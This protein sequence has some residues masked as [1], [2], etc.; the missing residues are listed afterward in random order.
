MLCFMFPGQPLAHDAALPGDAD[1]AEISTL[2]LDR[3]GLDPASFSWSNE[4]HTEQVALQVY[5]VAMS[6]HRHRRLLAEGGEPAVIAEHSMGI[7]AALAA[8]G[9]I[10]EGDA[11]EMAFRAGDAME[12]R[13]RGREYALGCVVGM[14]AEQVRG[15]AVEGGVFL[16]NH[17]TSHHVLLAGG[18]H[19]MEA[20][21]GEAQRQGAFSVNLFPCDAPL[22][23][24]LLAEAEEELT[25][26]FRDYRYGDPAIPLMNHIDQRFLTSHAI[27]D[28]LMRELTEAV[29]WE[30]TYCG[31][32][33]FGVTR[34][35]EVGVGDALKK[36]NR[37]IESRL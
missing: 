33:A 12:R 36:F 9:S 37:W 32:K 18:R 13:F 19:E 20:T 26:L 4:A 23:T 22:H 24:P 17:N 15:V 7:Y 14:A 16:A 10:S 1:F 6:L 11:L 31:L 27:P 21:L 35:V 2:A 28:F 25:A 30:R 5:G 34:F 3:T 8:C 29:Q